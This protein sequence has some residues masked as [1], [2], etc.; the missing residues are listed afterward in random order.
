M[1][2]TQLK[3]FYEA[4]RLNSISRAAES[5]HVS[6][7]SISMA[8]KE[9]ELEFNVRLIERRYKR[10]EL[11][12]DGITLRDMAE[13]LVRHADH[14]A[15]K[16][17]SLNLSKKPVRLGSPPMVATIALPAIYGEIRTKYPDIMFLT[18]E[19]GSNT[20]IKNL[21]ENAL[22]L[23]FVVH[24]KPLPTEFC[25]EAITR[26]QIVWCCLENH[27]LA[28]SASVTMQDL[29][30]EPLVL[31]QS[32]FSL[33]S[34]ISQSFKTAGIDPCVIHTTAQFSTVHSFIKSG[35]ATGFMFKFAA[36][37]I[38]DVVAIPLDPPIPLQ[39]S[40]VW[41]KGTSPIK[42]SKAI[43]EIFKKCFR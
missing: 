42:H 6:Q 31:F 20:C 28:K 18:D 21:R 8:I 37:F 3:Y 27:P 12:E 7:P 35:T 19:L 40:L 29:R 25:S 43:I 38:H 33:W 14:V 41:P 34:H 23:A 10:F 22:D 4:C 39:V 26:T 24:S 16:M 2:L 15:E 1:K 30:D 5:L 32:G 36:E 17:L 9:L 13:N 11:T